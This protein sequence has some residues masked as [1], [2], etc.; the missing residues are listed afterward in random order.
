ML[1]CMVEEE[2]DEYGKVTRK[3][4]VIMEWCI[5]SIEEKGW[6]GLEQKNRAKTSGGRADGM[7]KKGRRRR[8]G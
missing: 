4:C 8:N 3:G 5:V 6:E 7:R 1:L 2:Q